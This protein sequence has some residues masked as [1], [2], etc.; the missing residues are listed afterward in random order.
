MVNR[1]LTGG[2]ASSVRWHGCEILQDDRTIGAAHLLAL[3]NRARAR[4][5]R[6]VGP[7]PIP[8]RSR[9]RDRKGL[10][11]TRIQ[12]VGKDAPGEWRQMRGEGLCRRLVPAR[13]AMGAQEA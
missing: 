11:G 13:Q 7:A 6:A 10:F 8:D 2:L 12:I 3:T 5:R 1:S 9:G 4:L